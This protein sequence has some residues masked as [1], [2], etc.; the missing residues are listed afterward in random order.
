MKVT[1]CYEIKLKPNQKQKIQLNNYFYEAKVLYNYLLNCSNIFAVHSCKIKHVWKFDRDK[2]KVNVE[3]ISLPSKLKQNVHRQMINSIAALSASKK[4]G[5][6]VGNLKFKSEI[7]TIDIDNQSYQIADSHHI[8]LSGFG[9]QKIRCLGLHQFDESVIKF[10]N[11]KLMKRDDEYF[12][13]ICVLKEIT[14][15]TSCNQN[16]GIDFGIESNLTL[17]TREK[18]NCKI[19]ETARLKRLQRKLARS[20]RINNRRTNNQQKLLKQIHK[21]YQ[22]VT[23]RKNDF[24]NKL[25]HQLDSYDHVVF[26]N[27]QIRG[28]KNLK[29]CRKTIQHSCLGSIKQKLVM[30]SQEEPQRYIMLDK[31]FPTT[32]LCPN[33]GQKNRHEL[34]ERTYHCSCGYTED[35]DIHAAKNMLRFAQL[36]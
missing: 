11:A 7:N 24:V 17:S 26:Q 22:K 10:R 33:C 31:W 6:A 21:E 32:Q 20:R 35:R 2:Q 1:R 30:K 16:V 25:L 13:K 18:F 3:L 23:N 12:L 5:N 28:W 14:D 15:Y 19:E 8:K 9:R 29:S 4:K 27:E 34:D 36:Q